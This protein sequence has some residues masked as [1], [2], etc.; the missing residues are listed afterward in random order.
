MVVTELVYD[1]E[2]SREVLMQ[3]LEQSKD[4]L[5]MVCPWLRKNVVDKDIVSSIVNLLI[6]KVRID[7][8]WGYTADFKDKVLSEQYFLN[9]IENDNYNGLKDIYNL[10][11]RFE[12]YFKLKFLGTHEKYLVCDDKFAM[13]GSHNFLS[14]RGRMK[15]KEIGVYTTDKNIIEQL[16]E[17]YDNSKISVVREKTS[18]EELWKEF[19]AECER[20]IA[21]SEGNYNSRLA[22]KLGISTDDLSKLEWDIIENL[23]DDGLLYNY[24]MEFSDNS[25]KQILDKITDLQYS[26][27][28]YLNV[29]F[30]D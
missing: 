25:P 13:L 7:I 2:K 19:C 11:T 4:R 10:E 27:S 5:I 17:H 22:D 8:G 6:S 29:N 24:I 3:A 1:A 18:D 15:V 28:V 9:L 30:F 21:M 14:S 20:R 23:S 16:I 26:N 12:K